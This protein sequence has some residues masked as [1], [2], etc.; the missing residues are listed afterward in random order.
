ML[1]VPKFIALD[2]PCVRCVMHPFGFKKGKIQKE[3]LMP[4]PLKTD[5]SL[6]RLRYTTRGFCVL[7]GRSIQKGNSTFRCLA[8]LTKHEVIEVNELSKTSVKNVSPILSNIV[9]GPM[10]QGKY[11]LDCDVYVD[12]PNVELPMHADLRYNISYP[13]PNGGEVATRMRRYAHVLAG[14]MNVIHMEATEESA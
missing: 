1:L 2:E 3:A 9:Y 13:H 14:K 5:V 7:H 12:D 6:L 8:T 4:P 10:H 11:V